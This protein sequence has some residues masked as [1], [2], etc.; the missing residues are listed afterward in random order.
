MRD[1]ETASRERVSFEAHPGEVVVLRGAN[2]CG[3]TSLLRRL[4]GL[5]SPLRGGLV[6]LCGRD[7]RA[8]A[9]RERARRVGLVFQRSLDGLVGLTVEGEH[10]LRGIAPSSWSL[11]LRVRIVTTLSSGEARRVAIGVTDALAPSVLLMDEVTEGLDEEARDDLLRFLEA[12]RERGCVVAADHAGHLA[13]IATRTIDLTPRRVD[14]WIPFPSGE[15]EAVRARSHA[16]SLGGREL[17]LPAISAGVGVHAIVGPNG[18]GK[19]TLLRRLTGLAHAEG[20]RVASAPPRP[21]VTTRFSHADPRGYFLRESVADELAGCDPAIQVLFID[22]ELLRRHPLTL[23]GGEAHRVSLA[24]VLGRPARAY[25]LDEPEANLD[26][27]GRLALRTALT[28]LTE[29][30]ACVILATH[31][32]GLARACASTIRMG[33]PA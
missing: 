14:A 15:R 28:M 11:R 12:H 13:K 4:A 10:R 22:N 7:A 8:W 30:G 25:L 16:V 18:C 9:S 5:D 24:K 2:G 33:A 29:R 1:F 32:E 17:A 20:V 23:S 27:G 19:T 26:A 31:D 3:K 6:E 21:G